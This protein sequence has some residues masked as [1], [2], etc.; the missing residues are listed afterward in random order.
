MIFGEEN[1]VEEKTGQTR[2]RIAYKISAKGTFQ[3]DIT[4]EAEDVETAMENLKKALPK[5][6]EL[7]IS[8]GAEIA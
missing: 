3:P 5:V 2:V 1:T 6:K 7:A 4:S 8:E